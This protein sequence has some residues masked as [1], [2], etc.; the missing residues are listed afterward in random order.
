MPARSLLLPLFLLALLGATPAPATAQIFDVEWRRNLDFGDVWSGTTATVQPNSG[1][2]AQWYVEAYFFAR[3][4][5]DFSLPANLV[6]AGNTL[7]ISFA[8]D[9]AGWS[10]NS[11]GFGMTRFDPAQGAT[12][13]AGLFSGVYVWLGGTL[14]PPV[15]QP[16]GTYTGTITLIVTDF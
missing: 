11:A 4:T 5:L 15:S 2:A 12:A 1:S 10:R 6:S 13:Q 9:A 3:M 8:S 14:A 16:A 7:P